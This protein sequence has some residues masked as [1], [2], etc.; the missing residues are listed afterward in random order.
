[1]QSKIFLTNKMSHGKLEACPF[2]LH[3]HE[4]VLLQLNPFR[5]CGRYKYR[6]DLRGDNDPQER[7]IRRRSLHRKCLDQLFRQSHFG[8][9]RV[10]CT[11]LSRRLASSPSDLAGG[12]SGSMYGQVR[13]PQ[14][15]LCQIRRPRPQEGA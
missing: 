2:P 5:G 1:M 11:Q 8:R 15:A 3:L 10:R 9:L 12:E 7:K 14:G 13:R 6:Q 4:I